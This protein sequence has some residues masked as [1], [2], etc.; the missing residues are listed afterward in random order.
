ML[1]QGVQQNQNFKIDDLFLDADQ[2]YFC[3]KY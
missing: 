3:E 1:Y 2:H